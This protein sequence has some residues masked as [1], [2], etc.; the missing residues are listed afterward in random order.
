MNENVD[1]G[2]SWIGTGI[3]TITAYLQVNKIAQYAVFALGIVSGVLS[4]IY[5]IY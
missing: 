4:I 2:I 1:L 5:T 3:T